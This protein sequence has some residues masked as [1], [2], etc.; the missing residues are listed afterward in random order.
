MGNIGDGSTVFTSWGSADYDANGASITWAS[1]YG[2]Y[3][4]FDV[5]DL[6]QSIYDARQNYGFV[7]RMTA[8]GYNVPN[9]MDPNRIWL[10]SNESA[11]K[12]LLEITYSHGEPT[13]MYMLTVE[14]GSGDGPAEAGLPTPIVA[15]PP[16]ATL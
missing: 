1:G 15:G 2:S 14:S 5:T 6:V 10:A 16:F 3:N 13:K 11:R 9:A 8:S 4:T 7:V 12:P